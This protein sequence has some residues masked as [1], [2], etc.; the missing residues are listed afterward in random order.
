MSALNTG[1]YE[2]VFAIPEYDPFL[3]NIIFDITAY[4]P[5]PYL[6]TPKL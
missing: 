6:S 3:V 2:R 1:G 4:R 5:I